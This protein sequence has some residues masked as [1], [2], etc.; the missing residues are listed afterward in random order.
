M[1]KYANVI[2]KNWLGL[3]WLG[4]AWLGFSN[5]S[6]TA[7]EHTLVVRLKNFIPEMT[8]E[9]LWFRLPSYISH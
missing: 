9:P 7:G 8:W 4:L 6:I 2:Y 5:P 3:A 1:C